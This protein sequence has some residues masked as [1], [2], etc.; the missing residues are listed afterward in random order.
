MRA[1]LE[2]LRNAG[3]RVLHYV[4]SR[5]LYRDGQPA[6]CC[7]CCDSLANITRR[8]DMERADFPADGIFTDNVVTDAAHLAFYREVQVR[9]ATCE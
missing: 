7:R 2:V 8:I 3:V 1:D 9:K 4:H 5:E 6:P